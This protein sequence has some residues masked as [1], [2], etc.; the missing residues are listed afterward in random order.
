MVI[1]RIP[2]HTLA[3]T[4][5][6]YGPRFVGPG[7]PGHPGH[8]A[9]RPNEARQ[10]ASQLEAARPKKADEA[11]GREQA[12]QPGPAGHQATQ[13]PGRH[14]GQAAPASQP[15]AQNSI[16]HYTCRK[17]K[18]SH[19][20][21]LQNTICSYPGGSKSRFSTSYFPLFYWTKFKFVYFS[22]QKN[23]AQKCWRILR[24]WTLSKKQVREK[25]F[26]MTN[27]PAHT[28]VVCAVPFGPQKCFF[29]KKVSIITVDFLGAY[30]GI[31]F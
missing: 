19:P 23:V 12:G 22:K 9:G 25:C 20:P 10:V 3:H 28:T 17:R 15:D 7:R 26:L 8:P 4:L 6:I 21:K 16:F 31:E 24:D 11:A 5:L 13:A 1:W 29:I 2:A 30:P 27:L 14:P 18:S